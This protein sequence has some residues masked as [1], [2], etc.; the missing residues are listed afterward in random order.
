MKYHARFHGRAVGAIG[1]THPCEVF[2]HGDTEDAARL[3]LYDTHEHI[4]GAALVP[5][6]RRWVLTHIDS[7]GAR[8]LSQGVQ[9]RNTYDTTEIVEAFARAIIENNT[10]ARVLDIFGADPNFAALAVWCWPG[11]FD[12]IGIYAED[13]PPAPVSDLADE[14]AHAEA[15]AAPLAAAPFSLAPE[16]ERRTPKNGGLF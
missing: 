12:P 11:H 4:S 6:V 16:C 3:A 14:I 1:S 5:L 8:V 2:V 13:D 9:G 10:A 15:T 7:T